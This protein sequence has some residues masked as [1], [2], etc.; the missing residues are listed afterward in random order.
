MVADPNFLNPLANPLLIPILKRF[1]FAFILGFILI[2]AL[3]KFNLKGIWNHELGKRYLSWFIIGSLY[4]TAIF[5]GGYPALIFLAVIMFLAIN[6]YSK[7]SSLPNLFKYILYLLIPISILLTSFFPERFYILPL[8]YFLLITIIGIRRN[9][10][11][12]FY[13]MTSSYFASIWIIFSLCHFILL[14]HLN[15]EIDNTK[16]LLLLIGFAVPLADIGA[17]C[18]G[19]AFSITKLNN[20][21]IAEKISPNK[22]YAGILGDILGAGLGILFMHFIL[23]NYLI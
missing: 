7:I 10:N 5:F 6:E 18:I 17:Y 15:N 9:D 20:Y 23:K 11:K 16:S 13:F 3:R 22:T 21:K 4:L 1:F 12:G 2:L 19:K 8:I 14:G